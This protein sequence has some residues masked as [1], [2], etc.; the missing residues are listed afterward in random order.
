[1]YHGLLQHYR[2]PLVQHA[3]DILMNESSIA[4]LQS[5]NTFQ[6]TLNEPSSSL[7][8]SNHGD[9]NDDSRQ[10]KGVFTTPTGD[11]KSNKRQ[12][13]PN[14]TDE[15]TA[16]LS[17]QAKKTGVYSAKRPSIQALR[18]ACPYFKHDPIKFSK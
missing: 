3:L 6:N 14:R 15:D 7:G 16:R 4:D 10:L 5:Q 18:F 2:E 11:R 1:M 13:S 9:Q 8:T 17:K 12:R